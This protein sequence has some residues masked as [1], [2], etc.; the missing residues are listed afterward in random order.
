MIN[1]VYSIY[2][3]NPRKFIDYMIMVSYVVF[4]IGALIAVV[5]ND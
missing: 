5:I 1:V 2:K 3:H 4:M